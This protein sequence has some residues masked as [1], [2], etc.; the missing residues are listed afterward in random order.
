MQTDELFKRLI[1]AFMA[2]DIDAVMALFA[3][4]ALLVDPHYPVPRMQG[5]VAIERA[6]AGA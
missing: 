1:D 2:K 6:Y 4:D 3:D 5:R